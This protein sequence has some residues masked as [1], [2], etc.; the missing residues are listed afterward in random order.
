MSTP[1]TQRSSVLGPSPRA[2][3]E[4]LAYAALVVATLSPLAVMA[5]C[6]P[7]AAWLQVEADTPRLVGAS[8]TVAA[9]TV[10]AH[11]LG[12]SSR[13]RLGAGFAASLLLGALLGGTLTGSLAV[14]TPL[15]G[16]A[17]LC[18][19]LL[20]WLIPR[21]PP[22][23]D[24][25]MARRR[26]PSALMV[27]LGLATVTLTARVSAF[28][29]D[30]GRPELSA[31]PDVTFMVR[32]S[33]LTAY[34]EGERLATLGVDNVYDSALWP[35]LNGSGRE[36]PP[37]T[38]A[39]FNLDAFAYPPPFLL[40]PKALRAVSGDFATQRA[41]WFAV[42]G[43]T[44]A[45]GLWVLASLFTGRGRVRMLLLA[46]LVWV[47]APTLITLQ[48]G[49]VHLA[50]IVA[51]MLALVAFERRQPALGGALLAFAVLSKVSP[52]ILGL[53]LLVQ[54][55]F[56]DALWTAAFGVGFAGLALLVFGPAP[57]VQFVTYQLPRLGSGEALSFLADLESVVINL[58]PFGLPFKL[59]ALGVDVADPWSA[60]RVLNQVFTVLIVVVA[61]VSARRA[62]GFR[63]NAE[64]WLALLTL[65]S[66]QSP[67]APAYATFPM[68]WLL[69]IRAG[70]AS[71]WRDTLGIAGVWGCLAI[72]PTVV[73]R[74]LLVY[75]LLQQVVVFGFCFA[76]LLRVSPPAQR[77]SEPW[78]PPIP[79]EPVGARTA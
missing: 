59:D 47:S 36:V 26:A 11:A 40:V 54:G 65:S 15:L 51:A 7:V 1:K 73:P 18:V 12:L 63:A 14:A 29:G 20:A 61:V 43:L 66:L 78:H 46:P 77:P 8:L 72:I 76:A 35:D 56:R 4:R 34:V 27:V 3:V 60:A 10:L 22:E 25:V 74:P 23:L 67:L 49:N 9:V 70:D 57:F 42:N 5:L 52:G 64:V 58:S 45:W 2:P 30:A 37:A 13:W 38:Y 32:H 48:V 17:G 31:V 53:V 75:T 62:Q 6:R 79:P 71:G 24:G 21:L 33:C 69:T 41:L 55:R 28:M 19:L 44:L 50:V 39:P 16:V 68:F